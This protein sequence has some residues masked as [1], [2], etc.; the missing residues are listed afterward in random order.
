MERKEYL[1]RI[2]QLRDDWVCGIS[3][4]IQHSFKMV[5]GKP[6]TPKYKCRRGW[7]Q[8]VIASACYGIKS[9]FVDKKSEKLVEDFYRYLDETNFRRRLTT[10]EDIRRGDKV[11]TSMIASL[12]ETC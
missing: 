1:R 12:E 9:G 3:E 7:F 11:L 10:E 6:I 2:R 5:D 4:E 8:G